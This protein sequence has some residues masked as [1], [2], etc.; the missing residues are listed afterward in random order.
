MALQTVKQ[1]SLLSVLVSKMDRKKPVLVT[2]TITLLRRPRLMAK[3]RIQDRER[4]DFDDVAHEH[5]KL[6]PV[7]SSTITLASRRAT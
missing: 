1:T 3:R 6:K 4:I 2:F 7:V 5:S